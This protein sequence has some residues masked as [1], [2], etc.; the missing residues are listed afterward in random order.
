MGRETKIS[1]T[2]EGDERCRKKFL[3]VDGVAITQEQDSRKGQNEA[4]NRS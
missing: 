4:L 2:F 1:S 3:I